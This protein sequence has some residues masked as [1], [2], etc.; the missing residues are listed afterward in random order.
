MRNLSVKARVTIWF[1]LLMLLITAASLGFVI[2]VGGSMMESYSLTRLAEM[3]NDNADE[4]RYGKKGLEVD[5]DFE[6]Y[7]GGAYTLI[8]DE[9]GTLLYGRVPAGFNPREPFLEGE[10]Y[11]VG[12]SGGDFY[13]YDRRAE[14]LRGA[15]PSSTSAREAVIHRYCG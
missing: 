4:L 13:L 3:V 12:S 1:T 11:L 5:D 7:A 14:R 10:P 8:Y 9:A 2:T 6:P 15:P